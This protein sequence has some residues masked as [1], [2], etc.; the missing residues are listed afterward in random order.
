MEALAC[1]KP[2]LVSDIPGNCEW[3]TPG[4]EGWLFPDR[5]EDALVEAMLRVCSQP[6]KLEGA[7]LAARALAEKRANWTNNFKELLRA[8][9]MASQIK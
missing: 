5:N 8:Y 4:R 1:G 9:E 2:V 6:E 3:I 7:G